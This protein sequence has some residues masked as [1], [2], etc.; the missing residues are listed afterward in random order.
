ML[1]LQFV[2]GTEPAIEELS[3]T[4][5]R[6]TLAD[7]QEVSLM[8]MEASA[9]HALQWEQ[10]QVYARAIMAS[11]KDSPERILL[12]RQAYDTICAILSAQAADARQPMVMGLDPRYV[13]LVLGL[14]GRQF[15]AG[16]SSPRLF[17]IGYGCGALLDEVRG[18]GYAVGGIEVSAIMRAQAV[19]LLGR[20]HAAALLLGDLRSVEPEALAGRPTLVYW[21]DVFEHIPSDE[22]GDYLGHIHR[23]LAP[24]GVL[25]TITPNWLLRPMDVTGDFCPPRTQARGLHLKEYRLA[26]VT[27]LLRE[28]GF[29]RVATPL[30]ATHRRLVI[31]GG[32]GRVVKQ[33]IE[34]WL[35]RLPVSAAR[36]LCRGLAMSATIAWK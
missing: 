24:G 20:R 25:V 5:A 29:R 11:P 32:G 28:A 10:E 35:D 30:L 16:H 31:C 36:L 12:I 22:I 18:F 9:L 34:P 4:N 2:P 23:L 33:F 3:P 7:G 26:E 21:N 6:V 8:R 27:R 17:E 13:R 1:D 15:E 14:L 19:E